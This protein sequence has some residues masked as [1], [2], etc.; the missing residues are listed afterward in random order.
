V[1]DAGLAR[2]LYVIVFKF[3]NYTHQRAW[4]ESAERQTWLARVRP[5][6]ID[7]VKETVLTGL[8]RWFTLCAAPNVPPPPRYKMAVVTLCVIYSLSYAL[9]LALAPVMAQCR[10]C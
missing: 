6:C 2:S 7:D 3:D 8:E 9:R 5:L 4:A 10:R 1:T